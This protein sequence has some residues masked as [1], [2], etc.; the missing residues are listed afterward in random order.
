MSAAT[1]LMT[2]GRRRVF[3]GSSGPGRRRK[4]FAPGLDVLEARLTPTTLLPGFAEAPIATGLTHPTAMQSAPDGR[5]F[6][7][8]QGGSVKLVADDGSTWT[9]LQLDVDSLGERGLLGIAFDPGYT[10]NHFVYLYYTN[11]GPGAAPWA[12]GEHNQLSRFTVD[13]SDPSRPTFTDEAPILDW[14]SLSGASNHNGGALHFGLDGM[15]YAVAGDNAQSFNQGGSSYRVSQTLANLLGKQLR[16]DVS[17]FNRGDAARDDTAIGHLIPPD[18]P[19]VGTAA[20]INQLIYALGLR[21]PF[22]FAVQPG[23]GRIFINDVGEVTWEEIDESTPG[24]NFGWSGGNTDGFGHPSPPGPGVYH[25][26]L[27]AYNHSGG[28]AGGGIAIVGSTFYNPVT[29]QFPGSYVGKYFYADLTGWIRVFDP[30]NPGDIS[31]PD[32]STPFAS[33][34]I[35]S[36]VDLDVDPAGNLDYLSAAG[37]IYRVSYQGARITTQPASQVLDLGHAV[38][39]RVTANGPSLSYRWQHLVAGVWGDVGADS[40]TF[41]IGAV[42]AADAG[43]Y[44]VTVANLAG[45][46][47]SAVATLTV[48]VPAAPPTIVTQPASQRANIGQ[49]A[50]FTVAAGGTAPQSYQWQHLVNAA[51]ENVGPDAPTFTIGSV[52]DSDAGSYRVIASNGAGSVTSALATLAI[53]QSPTAT[54]TSPASGATFDWGQSIQF[55]GVGSDPE[56]GTLADDRYSWEVRF[57]HP[58]SPEVTGAPFRTVRIFN[59]VATGSF[60]ADFPETSTR[61]WYRIILTVADTDGAT[62]STFIDVHPHTVA[63]SLVSEP[64]GLALELDG[65]RIV[66]GTTVNA[67]VGQ[68]RTLGVVTPQSVRDTSYDFISWSD[69]GAA[70]HAITTPTAP[71]TYTAGFAATTSPGLKAEFFDYTTR[72]GRLPDLTG[73]V[74]DVTLTDPS[75]HHPRTRRPWAGLGRRFADTFATRHTGYLKVDTAGRYTLSLKSNDGSRLWLDGKLLI[76]NDGVHRMLVR[77]KAISLTT[78][79]HTLRVE[80]FEN[81]GDAGLILSWAGPGIARQVVSP[82]SLLHGPART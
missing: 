82:G 7:L 3:N 61:V 2:R 1:W 46:A 26:P 16:I 13:D 27:L 75:I 77:S 67:T 60:L 50:T 10:T 65:V 6:V 32:T 56:E 66:G 15:L 73:R 70:S 48:D 68:P 33:E 4:S 23:T 43:D 28:P 29:Q 69:G 78:G 57:Y 55:A 12:T 79:L 38:T 42:S 63:L 8:E 36:L 31:N 53:D 25:D 41:A 51:W 40:S 81:K 19:F 47:T 5:L 54:I 35:G 62:A 58:D 37:A 11:P 14:D 45:S 52:T 24:A 44:R 49:Q 39:F 9:A 72:L 71:A 64:A 74:A 18:N 22:T 34:T 80:F 30:A 76:V 20:G 59:G 21:N 17:A